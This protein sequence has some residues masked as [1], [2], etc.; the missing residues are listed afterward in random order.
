MVSGVF[1][2]TPARRAP[3]AAVRTGLRVLPMAPATL[4]IIGFFLVPIL[5][6]IYASMTNQGLSGVNA[7]NPQ[8]IGFENYTF[9][10]TDPRTWEAL[11]RTALFVFFSVAGQ[12][13]LGFVVAYGRNAAAPIFQNIVGTA[14]VTAWVVPEVVAGFLWYTFLKGETAGLN[15]ILG[16]VGLAPQHWLLTDP[17]T[18]VIAINIWRGTAFSLLVYS[19][20][21]QDVPRDVLEAAEIDGANGLQRVFGVILPIIRPVIAINV[22]LT[23]LNTLGVFGIIWITTAGGPG[24]MSETLPI[25]MYTQAYDFGLIGYGSAIAVLLLTFGIV[26]SLIY[27]YLFRVGEARDV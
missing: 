5:W 15:Q 2:E 18:A 1:D 11:G 23:T 6:A 27:V 3:R 20:A 22:V 14:M 19:A 26:A 21:L 9:M 16:L 12:N 13:V 10:L 17:L 24:T 4:M 7:R 25:L 8:F